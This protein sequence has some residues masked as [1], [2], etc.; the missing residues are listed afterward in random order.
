MFPDI[1]D[2]RALRHICN[3]K[4]QFISLEPYKI[5]LVTRD[6][7]TEV[8][9]RGTVK[10]IGRNPKTGKKRVISLSDTLYSPGFHTNLVSYATLLKKGGR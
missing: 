5:T 9:A 1:L 2:T 3:D 8:I 4:S 10:L 6:S 7:S